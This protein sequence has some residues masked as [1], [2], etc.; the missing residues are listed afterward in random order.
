MNTKIIVDST[1][2][3]LPNL[4]EKVRIVPLT[5][6]FGNTEYIDGI[7][8]DHKTFYEKLIETDVLPTTSQATPGVFQEAFKEIEAAGDEAVVITLSAKLSGT[9]QSAHIAAEDFENIYIVDSGSGAVGSGIL[10]ELAI[11][12]AEEG[13]N[14]KEIVARLEEEKKNIVIVALL[15]TLEYLKKG[16]RI[17][18]TVAFAGAVLNLKPVL[19]IID[20]EFAMLGKARGS[21][22]GNNLLVQEIEKAGGV[23]FT[24]PIL[25]GYTGISD[26]LLLK[27]IEDSKHIWENGVDAVRYTTI[28]SSVG[29]H[30]GPGAIAVAFFKKA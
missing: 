2:D 17:S 19:S 5:I 7:T 10:T 6:H 23:D 21:K 22:Q 29:T 15:D 8:I 1:T 12:Y 24:K 11:K 26:A 3:L 16:G 9:N 27:Y 18:K 13:M 20:G 14:A 4:K 28:G 25:L 30:A